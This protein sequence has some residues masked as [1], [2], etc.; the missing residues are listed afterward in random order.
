[1]LLYRDRISGNTDDRK[2]QE[3][4]K[5]IILPLSVVY[6]QS[7]FENFSLLGVLFA[8]SVFFV[9]KTHFVYLD[10]TKKVRRLFILSALFLGIGLSISAQSVYKTPSGKKYHLASCRMV[11]NVSEKLTV[12]EAVARGLEP[13]KI[14]KPDVAAPEVDSNKAK[15]Q[16]QTVQCK[17]ITKAGTRCKHMTR[18]ANGYCYQHQPG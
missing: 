9:S 2:G 6:E 15:G 4:N 18:I 5:D 7:R 13:C 16:A 14:C 10:T 3:E 12:A 17:G 11:E 1:M 8:S